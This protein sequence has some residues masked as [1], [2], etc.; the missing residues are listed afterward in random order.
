MWEASTRAAW[1]AERESTR[2]FYM[3][4][5]STL[6]DLIDAQNSDYMDA[7]A[8]SLDDW[9]ARIDNLGSLLN[10]VGGML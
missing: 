4:G 6:G 5:L 8:R 2:I 7:S 10:L 9:N 3:N 1:E